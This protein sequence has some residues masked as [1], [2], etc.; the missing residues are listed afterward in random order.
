MLKKHNYENGT[1]RVTFTLPKDI[2]ADSA[3]LVGSF[4]EWDPRAS[5]MARNDEGNFA[6]NMDL[7]DRSEYQF[8][9]F[10]NG[11]EWYND[12]QADG[13]L[14]NTYGGENSVVKT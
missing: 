3:Y 2:A 8:R 10:V 9:Y 5:L 12:D 1:V 4:N 14:P 6:I 7:A 11:S 13:Y